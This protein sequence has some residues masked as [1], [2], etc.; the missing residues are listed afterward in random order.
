MDFMGVAARMRRL[1]ETRDATS[2]LKI[3]SMKFSLTTTDLQMVA[4]AFASLLT[5]HLGRLWRLGHA[6]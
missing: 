5:G 1:R 4:A 3:P 6:S 2:V